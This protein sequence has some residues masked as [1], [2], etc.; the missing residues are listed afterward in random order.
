MEQPARHCAVQLGRS[1]VRVLWHIVDAVDEGTALAAV[2]R[3][4]GGDVRGS[5]GV[6]GYC[7]PAWGD[8]EPHRRVSMPTHVL[9]DCCL[10]CIVKLTKVPVVLLVR[11]TI[12]EWQGQ[13]P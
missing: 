9:Q 8:L 5:A 4:V 11:S 3:G 10:R 13:R 1:P 2:S 7:R 12:A 6:S